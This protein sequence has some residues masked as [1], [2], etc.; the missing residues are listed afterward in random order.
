MLKK[1][2]FKVNGMEASRSIETSLNSYQSAQSHISENDVHNHRFEYLKSHKSVSVYNFCTWIFSIHLG[3]ISNTPD[4]FDFSYSK[5]QNQIPSSK[6]LVGA[7]VYELLAS[8]KQATFLD[9]RTYVIP[10]ILQIS[11]SYKKIK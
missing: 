1:I 10:Y 5:N 6:Q 7:D 11:V 8:I 2:H 4:S 3:I 9:K